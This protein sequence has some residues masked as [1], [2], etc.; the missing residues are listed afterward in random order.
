MVKKNDISLSVDEVVTT[1]RVNGI[2]A[3]WEQWV[4]FMSDNHHDSVYCERDLEREH[5]EEAKKRNAWI[6]ILGDLFDAMQGRFD[7]RRSMEE[8]RPEYRREDYYDYVVKD[9]AEFL[10]PYNDNIKLICPG[11]H[12]LGV[13]RYANTNL[14]DRLVYKLRDAGANIIHGGYGGWVRFLFEINGGSYPGY[15]MKYFHGAGGEAPVTRGVIQTNRQAVYLP[16]ADIVV[17]GHNHNAY[18]VPISRERVSNQGKLY[19]DI[20]HH[21]RVPGYKNGYGNG[22]GGWEVTRGGVP[23]PVGAVW[24]RMYFDYADT[25]KIKGNNNGLI[26][27]QFIPDIRGAANLADVTAVYAGKIY[28]E[29]RGGA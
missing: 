10:S 12:E 5:L 22:R 19:M 6:F 13:L 24:M 3:G 27:L 15:S 17:N 28:D 9:I 21:I 7:P 23:K 2:K 25:R 8:L 26:K 14:T 1:I 18:Y 20:Q 16:D 4:L 11:N 29:D